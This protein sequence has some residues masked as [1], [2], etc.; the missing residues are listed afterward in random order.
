[1]DDTIR[2]NSLFIPIKWLYFVYFGLTILCITASF[3][4]QVLADSKPKSLESM[5][6]VPPIPLM[7]E[8]EHAL[9]LRGSIA[10]RS[11]VSMRVLWRVSGYKVTENG[12]WGEEEARELLFKPLDIDANKITFDGKTC[13]DIISK[14]EMVNAKEYLDRVYHTTP[15]ALS[16]E[17]EEVEVVKT[18]CDL[19]GFEEYM[20]L[21][22]RR[23]IIH[24]NGV[25]FFFKPA[26]NY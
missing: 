14:K 6:R 24:L 13:R 2:K 22:D 1:M 15:Q 11:G 18:N 20:R 9:G 19:P 12:L 26:V 23:L 7:H 21:R 25:F 8:I 4:G 17:D 5:L 10:V 16:I 3:P